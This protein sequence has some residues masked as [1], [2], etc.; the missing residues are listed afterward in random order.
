MPPSRNQYPWVAKTR[1]GSIHFLS[2]TGDL[3]STGVVMGVGRRRVIVEVGAADEGGYRPT[4][5]AF[6]RRA[7]FGGAG[8]AVGGLL[9]GGLPRLASS[10]P[11]PAQ[12]AEVLNFVLEIERLQEAFYAEA[13]GSLDLNGELNQF[14][15]VVGGHERAH[16]EF[17]EE[18]LGGAARP[19]PE[20][21]FGDSLSNPESFLTAVVA[22]EDLGVAAYN[23]QA[24]NLTPKGLA[25][26]A[27]I[28]SVEA[29]HASW[30]RGIAGQE[31]APRGSDLA[32]GAGQ[33]Q[34]AL[35]ELGLVTQ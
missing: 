19:A 10:A 14:V 27:R 23:G 31:P 22:L 3:L 7:L 30:A 9:I 20:F 2:E 26:A 33:A 34:T 6:R 25:S 13:T 29:R 5:G 8:V 21:D 32:F 24:T 1:R 17:I 16:R 18:T 15:R 35:S 28:A 12:D 4:S 11:S